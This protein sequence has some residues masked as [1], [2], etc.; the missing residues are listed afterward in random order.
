[1]CKTL[2]AWVLHSILLHSLLKTSTMCLVAA[3]SLWT[4][5]YLHHQQQDSTHI[6]SEQS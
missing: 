5:L 4:P 3:A 2:L 1:M 6:P